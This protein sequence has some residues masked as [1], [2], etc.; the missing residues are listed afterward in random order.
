MTFFERLMSPPAPGASFTSWENDGFRQETWASAVR[1]AE[2]AAAGLRDLG[3]APG[4]RVGCVL[5]NSFDVATGILGIWLAGGTVLSM[6]TPA[7]GMGL[8]EYLGQVHG[9]CDAAGTDLLILDD[10][11]ASALDSRDGLRV[12]SFGRLKTGRR[13]DPC[14]PGEDEPAFVQY[15]SGSTSTPKGCVLTPRAIGAQLDMMADRVG[16]EPGYDRGCFWLPLSHDMG[17]FACLMAA[18]TWGMDCR[19]STPIRFLRSPRTWLDDCAE[20]GATMAIGPTFGVGLALRA[21]KRW[22]PSE[23]LRLRMMIMGS[24]PVDAQALEGAIELLGP[25]GVPPEVFTPG[26][27]LAEATLA[28]SMGHLDQRA[29]VL[30]VALDA[31]YAGELREPSGSETEKTARMVSCGTPL[32]GTE[33]RIDGGDDVGEIVVKSPSLATGYLNDPE[34]TARTFPGGTELRTGD[35]GFMRDGELYV[36]GRQDDVISVGGRNIHATELEWR[37]GR[38]PRIRS[39]SC[40]LID[41]NDNG[42]RRLVVLSETVDDDVDFAAAAQ[43]MR[44]TVASTAG[45]GINECLFAPRG[46]LPKSPSGKVQRF[47]CRQYASDERTPALA[48]VRID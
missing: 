11:F 36:I 16:P 42:R 1:N 19:M 9:L 24:D 35:V 37:L 15:S 17:L 31:L 3:V 40:T 27:G 48:R 33:V 4:T 26:Y 43:S 44:T 32:P 30:P 14:L 13:L 34:R 20:H 21:A 5:T 8:D 12:A 7:R 25:L 47:R 45:I 18:W 23:Q 46:T 39:G 2:E 41:V 22:P 38:D 28:V 10:E 6:P 29:T